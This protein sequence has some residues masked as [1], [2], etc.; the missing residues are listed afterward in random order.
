[1]KLETPGFNFQGDNAKSQPLGECLPRKESTARET[2]CSSYV[3]SLLG[4]SRKGLFFSKM[5]LN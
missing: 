4:S 1:M 3:R 2:D 5:V